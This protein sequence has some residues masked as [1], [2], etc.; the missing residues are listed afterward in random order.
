[1]IKFFILLQ[2]IIFI[3]AKTQKTNDSNKYNSDLYEDQKL[4][5]SNQNASLK[6][7]FIVHRHGERTL[8]IKFPTDEYAMNASLWPGILTHSILIQFRLI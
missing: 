7:L 2:F 1:M 4:K 5:I 8:A 6:L 3:V